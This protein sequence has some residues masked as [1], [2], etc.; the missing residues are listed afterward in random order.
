MTNKCLQYENKKKKKKETIFC[1][2]IT[3]ARGKSGEN[4]GGGD[5]QPVDKMNCLDKFLKRI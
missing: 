4:E 3:W 1:E 5:L 2:H